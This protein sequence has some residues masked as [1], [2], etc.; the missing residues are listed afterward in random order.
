MCTLTVSLEVAS[1]Y[2]SQNRQNLRPEADLSH[3][4]HCLAEMLKTILKTSDVLAQHA[5]PEA[6]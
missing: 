1:Q 2:L 5:Y 3:L 6:K 4:Y